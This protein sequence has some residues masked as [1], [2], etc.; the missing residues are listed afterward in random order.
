VSRLNRIRNTKQNVEPTVHSVNFFKHGKLI[1]EQHLTCWGAYT[2]SVPY[3]TVQVMRDI[4]F[5]Y[6]SRSD[7]FAAFKVEVYMFNQYGKAVAIDSCDLHFTEND[8]S[9][10]TEFL[11]EPDHYIR[12]MNIADPIYDQTVIMTFT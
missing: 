5:T 3:K 12:I 1:Y 10:K 7:Q 6:Q 2:N 8:Q 11:I 9:T 4:R